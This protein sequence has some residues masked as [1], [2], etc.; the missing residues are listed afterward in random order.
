VDYGG[1]T[2][3]G[4]GVGGDKTGIGSQ[5]HEM[6]WVRRIGVGVGATGGTIGG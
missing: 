2:E 1:K 4:D 5:S 3:T 6:G